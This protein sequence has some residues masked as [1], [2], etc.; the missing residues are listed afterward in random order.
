[1]AAAATETEWD[2]DRMGRVESVANAVADKYE[3]DREE[4]YGETLL[5]LV[6]KKGLYDPARSW[7]SWAKKQATWAALAMVR[8]RIRRRRE[9]SGLEAVDEDGNTVPLVDV[10][11]DHRPSHESVVD[12][13]DEQEFVLAQLEHVPAESREVLSMRFGLGRDPMTF[14]EIGESLGIDTLAA[15]RR[16]H[17]AIEHVRRRIGLPTLKI[18]W[19][20]GY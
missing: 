19:E 12:D 16:F 15:R 17:R 2:A 6:R 18:A 3:V 14:D 5:L 9:M 4:L 10:I 7:E 13:A 1:M 8:E 11:P 20:G